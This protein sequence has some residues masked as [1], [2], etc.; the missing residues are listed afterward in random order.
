MRT[1]VEQEG[2]LRE[3]KTKLDVAV[4][5]A[6]IL[7]KGMVAYIAY[8]MYTCEQCVGAP[9]IIAVLTM[10]AFIESLLA[11]LSEIDND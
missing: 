5:H 11:N 7:K 1:S 6:A 3:Y 10:M 4:H 8:T 9:C 2:L